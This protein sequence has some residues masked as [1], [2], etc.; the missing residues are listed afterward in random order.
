MF[1]LIDYNLV[2]VTAC[3]KI[4]VRFE[5]LES[6]DRMS[7]TTHSPRCHSSSAREHVLT[8]LDG[9]FEA[10]SRFLAKTVNF[11]NS[12]LQEKKKKCPLI[13][14]MRSLKAA[15]EDLKIVFVLFSGSKLSLK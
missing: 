3:L 15:T 8:L 5:C 6:V 14:V 4:H 11:L 2:S 9:E 7:L 12:L 10:Y 13:M 1:Q